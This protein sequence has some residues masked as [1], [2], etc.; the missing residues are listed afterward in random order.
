MECSRKPSCVE[1]NETCCKDSAACP[2]VSSGVACWS[3][4][5]ASCCRRND[6]SRCVYCFVY[7]NFLLWT[8]S[9]ELRRTKRY[10]FR[11][12]ELRLLPPTAS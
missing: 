4:P 12:D 6:K 1:I 3:T 11:E 9:G 8:E 2:A 7:L 5:D 10:S